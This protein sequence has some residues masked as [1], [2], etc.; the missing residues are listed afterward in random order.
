MG[1]SSLIS[2]SVYPIACSMVMARPFA[3]GV[4]NVFSPGRARD[5]VGPQELE[6]R[7]RSY[8]DILGLT[9]AALHVLSNKGIVVRW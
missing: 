7:L 6:L 1:Y 9:I 5:L 8:C 4:A 2:C 3:H